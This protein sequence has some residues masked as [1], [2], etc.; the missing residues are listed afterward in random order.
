MTSAAWK[1]RNLRFVVHRTGP[2]SLDVEHHRLTLSML[3][4][5]AIFTEDGDTGERLIGNGDSVLYR[6]K[7]QRSGWYFFGGSTQGPRRLPACKHDG[8][9]ALG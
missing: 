4:G 1:T 7:A 3:A 8:G 5:I 6:A 2:L 9:S